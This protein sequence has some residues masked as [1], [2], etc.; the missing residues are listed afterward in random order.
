MGE[1]LKATETRGRSNGEK[2]QADRGCTGPWRDDRALTSG[3]RWVV[4]V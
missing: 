4:E 2:P 3:P 1:G